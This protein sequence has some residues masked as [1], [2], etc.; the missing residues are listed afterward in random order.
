V[1][2]AG[3][4]NAGLTESEA[5]KFRPERLEVDA[6]SPVPF[7]PPLCVPKSCAWSPETPC[8]TDRSTRGG[9]LEEVP[10][11]SREPTTTVCT[12]NV[13]SR[14]SWHLVGHWETL[15]AS[16][17]CSL[18][19]SFKRGDDFDPQRTFYGVYQASQQPGPGC[20]SESPDF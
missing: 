11:S 1:Q 10:L 20:A 9:P 4:C 15:R 3:E 6:M 8:Q 18:S 5:L 17:P 13:G 2:G 16:D 12:L 19:I 14:A 7:W